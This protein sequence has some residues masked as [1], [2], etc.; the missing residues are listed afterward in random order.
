MD[1]ALWELLEEADEDEPEI[2]AIVR[3]ARPDANVP[4]LRLVAR[5]GT[6]A[7]CRLL[8]D[9]AVAIRRDPRVLS[10]KAPRL[11]GP[12]QE[13]GRRN[14]YRLRRRLRP[15]GSD[16]R[17]PEHLPL[18]GAGVVV[19]VVDWGCDFDY[20]SFK[21][22]DGTTRLLA[23]WDQRRNEAVA[24]PAP[25]GYGV[26]HTRDQIDRALGEERPYAA[27]GYH[28]ADADREGRGTHGTH[29]LDI[30]AGNG[31]A[32][33]P[34]GLA[35]EAHI[36]FCHLA[37]RG[38]GG[39][40]TLGDSVRILEG[41][42]LVARTAAA[43]GCP[44]V[45]NI[46]VGRHGG[47]HDGSTLVEVALD[48]LLRQ[49]TGACVVQSAGNYALSATHS[50]GRFV[51]SQP[52]VLRFT[53]HARDH[54]PNEL[55]VWYSGADE[56]QV[57]VETPTGER[58]VP[59]AL[60]NRA[61]VVAGGRTV[62]RLY[63]RRRDPNNGDN[64]V[65]LFLDVGAPHGTWTVTLR[66]VRVEDGWFH[67]WLERD[68]ACKPC[69][70]RFVRAHVDAA[71]TTGT[72]AN[73][74]LPLVTGAVDGHVTPPRMARSSSAG[75]TRDGRSKPDLVADGVE[76]VAARSAPRGCDRSPGLL[77]PKSGTSMATP[78]VTGAVALCLEALGPGVPIEEV[79]ELVLRT[80]R[81]AAP[82]TGST[83]RTRFGCG[84]LDV[85]R[86]VAAVAAGWPGRPDRKENEMATDSTV[87]QELALAI[88]PDRLYRE[89]VYAPDQ[90]VARW[91]GD[92]FTTVARPGER[93][94]DQ[95]RTGDIL[96]RVALGE[97][98][99]GRLDVLEE[100]EDSPLDWLARLARVP[101]GQLLLR[102]LRA[103]GFDT[104]NVDWTAIPISRRRVMV[105]ELLVDTYRYPVNGAAGIV[106]NLDS[107]SKLIPNS[108]EGSAAATPM[109]A[110]NFDGVLTNFTAEDVMNRD[111][112]TRQGPKM[113]GIGVAQ[114]TYPP[115]RRGLFR[116]RHGTKP[117][118]ARIVFDMEAQIDYLVTELSND[119]P[120]SDAVLRNPAVTVADAADEVVYEVE[121]PKPIFLPSKQRRPRSDPQV[122]DVFRKRRAA[123]RRA[124]ADYRAA[125]PTPAPAPAETADR[126][127][128]GNTEEQAATSV[129]EELVRR[130]GSG[131]RVAVYDPGD[132]ELAAR[133][134][135]WARRE[136]AV[137]TRSTPTA[138]AGL[139]LGVAMSDTRGLV[140][141][142]TELGT[143]L[144]QATG[145][146]AGP[147]LIRTLALFAHG[148]GTTLAIGNRLTA[149][150]VADVVT[151]MAPVLAP[152]VTVVVYGCTV[153][154]DPGEEGWVATTMNGGGTRSLCAMLRDALVDQNKT[155]ATVWGHTEDGHTTRNW[156]LRR[157]Q[158]AGTAPAGG[159]G[160]PGQA[161]AGEI[162][163]GSEKPRALAQ[164]EEAVGAAGFRVIAARRDDFRAFVLRRLSREMYRGY[165]R[166]NRN[167]TH[168]GANLAERAPLYPDEVAEVIRSYWRDV[169][170]TPMRIA[171]FSR[172]LVAR[173]RS[174]GIVE[175]VP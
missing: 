35:P 142:V 163:F 17:R 134:A 175:S 147:A 57:Q 91:I 40:A 12:E 10:L 109:R 105:M 55:E 121:R 72:L 104:P 93:P 25:Y 149:G 95:P 34:V 83:D 157:F 154:A 79:R 14:G 31:R 94:I 26:L 36:V 168:G 61:V 30:A 77:V 148:W 115:R 151:R 171:E 52:R 24:G 47:P 123:A 120:R 5:F 78:H 101:Y 3:L 138:A 119:F 111:P 76:V 114:W 58:G 51:G 122:Q 20:P 68:E 165:G 140:R 143:A 103:L 39:L 164:V 32:G 48:E 49:S 33:G 81:A 174:M 85:S 145:E 108:I 73:G 135:E 28:P 125:H 90:P 64:H 106:G 170:W 128:T 118:G 43:A 150:N 42:D 124:L 129:G 21:W 59:V 112:A 46:S 74:R 16:R 127:E 159:K 126:P 131:V 9:D 113:P 155:S 65:D 132:R 53:T 4:G 37:D 1:P 87:D 156:S 160:S 158:A 102:P 7:T 62:G 56:L 152:D 116:H 22:P 130:F 70:A 75:P 69:Q 84:Q 172:R 27:L 162:V 117:A 136:E 137:G 107:E 144:A 86:L 18:T 97:P 50:S 89:L 6:V 54:T 23:L 92:R 15:T 82:A 98:G 167:L 67:A 13:V 44:W 71:T 169:Y 153:C 60:G 133:A 173:L 161:F 66:P 88:G 45:V 38:T 100:A 139:A 110:R 80:T 99:R 29:V 41:V 166:A 96:I 146:T 19:G 11:V 8:R 141:I 2:E 63:H